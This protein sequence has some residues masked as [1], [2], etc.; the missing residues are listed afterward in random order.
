[1]KRGL[2]GFGIALIFDLSLAGAASAAPE[3][4]AYDGK[5]AI[6]E[7]Q[8]GE[9]K[10]INGVDFWMRGAPPRRFQLIGSLTDERHKTGLWGAI[11]MSSLETDIA[12]AALAAGGN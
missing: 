5:N 8:G 2:L 11:R 6:Q 1:M 7:G 10:S 3:F 4:L 12:K 9:H